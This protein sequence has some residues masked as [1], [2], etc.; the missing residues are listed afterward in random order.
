VRLLRR[1]GRGV[2]PRRRDG[3]RRVVARVV[4]LAL[5]GWC[6]AVVPPLAQGVSA[7][8]V[9]VSAP[10]QN[11]RGTY[12]RPVRRS[13]KTL[14]VDATFERLL[15]LNVNTYVYSIKYASDFSTLVDSFLQT[16]KFH[17]I[18]VWVRLAPR[19]VDGDGN[20]IENCMLPFGDNFNSW[21]AAIAHLS[22]AFPETLTAWTIDDFS[23]HVR[24]F[25]SRMPTIRNITQTIQPSLK[26]L[27]IVYAYDDELPVT[28]DLVGQY[29]D[30]IILPFNDVPNRNTMMT[31][32]MDGQLRDARTRLPGKTLILMVYVQGLSSTEVR[33]D[34]DYVTTLTLQ[35][36]NLLREGVIN[37][38]VMYQLW[39]PLPGR[40]QFGGVNY[41]H[42]D[43]RGA[44][45]FAIHP[46]KPTA[47]GDFG[48]GY[49]S[50]TVPSGSTSCRLTAWH[51]DSRGVPTATGHRFKQ[52][53][54]NG[55]V[56]WEQDVALDPPEWRQTPSLNLWPHL[57]STGTNELRLRLI[58]KRGTGNLNV[59]LQ[60]DDIALSGGCSIGNPSF[61]ASGG[62][63]YTRVGGEVLGT[64][65]IYDPIFSET[66]FN[67]ISL[68]FRAF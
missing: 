66:I 26:F 63:T 49:T 36:M 67:C 6:V 58:E 17:G 13:D 44:A 15:A 18:K 68:I 60:F 31:A 53:L 10:L 35:G 12:E 62:W 25:R 39:L 29:I 40:P 51:Y 8:E 54:V 16:A 52:I 7:G 57:R 9:G 37:G 38:V 11:V 42:G 32:R 45:V 27:P 5:L 61:E 30:G 21:A 47:A 56:V 23:H 3:Q 43:G 50:I 55:T 59:R 24:D 19:C 46:D 28:I 64:Q 2:A 34:V 22:S 65:I 48:A 20:P 41:S 1:L 14:D 4:T 33:P